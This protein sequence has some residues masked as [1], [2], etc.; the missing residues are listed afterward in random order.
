MGRISKIKGIDLFVEADRSM[1]EKKNRGK[2]ENFRVVRKMKDD[3]KEY[4]K[5][6]ER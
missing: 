5:V 2:I 1:N 3:V 6:M 4:G